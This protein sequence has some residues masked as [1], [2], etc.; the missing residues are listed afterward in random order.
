MI[1]QSDFENDYTFANDKQSF[2]ALDLFLTQMQLH[3]VKSYSAW[4][5]YVRCQYGVIVT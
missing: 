1:E 3:N 4:C 5:L 2:E